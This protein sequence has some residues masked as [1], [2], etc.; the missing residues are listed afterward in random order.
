MKSAELT[1]EECVKEI[2]ALILTIQNEM[3]NGGTRLMNHH[4][5]ELANL[6]C[7]TLQAA[8][9]QIRDAQRKKQLAS[10]RAKRNCGIFERREGGKVINILE[11]LREK[12]EEA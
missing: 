1:V 4:E 3:I 11:E 7:L 12:Y 5:R 6:Q 8:I 9:N 10:K 2:D